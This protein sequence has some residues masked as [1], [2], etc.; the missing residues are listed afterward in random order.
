MADARSVIKSCAMPTLLAWPIGAEPH[1]RPP[2]A[3][4]FPRDED[5]QGS[6]RG[7]ESVFAWFPGAGTLDQARGERP[8]V[9]GLAIRD[10]PS[11]SFVPACRSPR[12]CKP[13]FTVGWWM[14]STGSVRSLTR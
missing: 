13:S 3:T 14:T 9:S 4:T 1:T 8:S 7:A 12:N 11:W 10:R 2:W 5:R 6:A